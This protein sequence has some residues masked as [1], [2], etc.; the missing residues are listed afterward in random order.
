[1]FYRPIQ[2]IVNTQNELFQKC[3]IYLNCS[4]EP[5]QPTMIEGLT[6]RDLLEKMPNSIE[7]KEL[8]F[9]TSVKKKDTLQDNVLKL[10]IMKVIVT[11]EEIVLKLVSNA[12]NKDIFQENAQKPTTKI[13]QV[14]GSQR[15]ALNVKNKGIFLDNV[16]RMVTRIKSNRESLKFVSNA[17]KRVTFLSSVLNLQKK[18]TMKD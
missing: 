16:Q 17:R 11:K 2:I 13:K 1:M 4:S 12:K 3:K 10:L 5:A 14:R 9:V 6:D 7:E 15:C 8:K 18:I